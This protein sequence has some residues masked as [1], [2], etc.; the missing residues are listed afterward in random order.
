MERIFITVPAKDPTE[1]TAA[2]H[3]KLLKL[4]LAACDT[5]DL[6]EVTGQMVRKRPREEEVVEDAP[7]TKASRPLGPITVYTDGACPNNGGS[8][9]R[10]GVGVYF[11]PGDPRNISERLSELVSPPTNNRAEMTAICLAIEAVGPDANVVIASDSMLCINTATKWMFSWKKKNWRKGGGKPVMNLDL[12]KRLFRLV[13][14]HRGKLSFK[15]VKA[16]C[17]IPGNEAAD[18]LATAGAQKN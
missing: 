11:G 17:G 3:A 2:A 15:Y 14:T 6:V 18:R 16:H 10:G 12:V 13:S 4:L 1:A 7:P 8:G 5:N 9:A